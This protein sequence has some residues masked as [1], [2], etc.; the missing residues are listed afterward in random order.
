MRARDAGTRRRGLLSHRGDSAR[1][2][3]EDRICDELLGG[4]RDEVVFRNVPVGGKLMPM[5]DR[6]LVVSR[7]QNLIDFRV[8]ALGQALATGLVDRRTP[9]D[10]REDPDGVG[11]A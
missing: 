2:T 4:D 9:R 6:G 10:V 3:K 11:S 7:G 1:W 8:T 5:Q